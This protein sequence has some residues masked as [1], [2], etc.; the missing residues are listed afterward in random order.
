[1]I[2]IAI[3]DDT[4]QQL[5]LIRDACDAF[6]SRQANNDVRILTFANPNDF[7]DTLEKTGGFDVALLDICMPGISGIDLGRQIRKRDDKTVL[8]YITTSD[9]FHGEAYGVKAMHY[10]HKPFSQADLWEALENAM[11]VAN[12]P[13]GKKLQVFGDNGAIHMV[14]VNKILYVE[15]FRTYRTIYALSGSCNDTKRTFAVLLEELNKLYPGQFISPVRGFI[16]NLA[17]VI[18][19]APEGI[20]VKGGQTVP[21]KAGS[22]RKLRDVYMDWLFRKDV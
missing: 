7:L 15:S 10:L 18:A 12:A 4:P 17:N 16:V 8:I 21:I 11:R 3:C 5:A 19:V 6:F 13:A 1:M 20:T 2:R 22:F 9:E 14:E